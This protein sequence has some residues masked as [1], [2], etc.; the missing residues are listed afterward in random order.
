MSKEKKV[1]RLFTYLLLVLGALIFL[2]P[3]FYMLVAS[4]QSNTEIVG[5]GVN[6]R[7]GDQLIKNWQALM[8]RYNY[9]LVLWNSLVIAV[10]S[11]VL[12][13]VSATMAGY[14]LAKYK[15][16]GS[17]W[18]FNIVM[19]SRMV[20]FFATLIPLFYLM[21]RMGL[22][23]T[24]AGIVIPSIA[25]T[26]SV[27]MMRQYSH[28][29]PTSL[30]EAARMDGASEWIIFSKIAVPV[31]RP[32][33][34]TTG[35]LIFMGSWNQY[36][37][38][39]VMLSETDKFTIP[40]VIRNLSISSTGEVINYGALMLVLATSVIPMVLIYA[41]AQAKFKENDIGAANK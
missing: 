7:F 24:Y 31:L 12:A 3:Y 23:N 8:A 38:P 21:S 16:R 17:S 13:T 27:F 32:T 37:F 1:N 20:P 5:G 39:L 10:L 41:W 9:P 14:A 40:L 36:L 2:M 35:L 6:F 26:T 34:I 29:F 15:F 22:A 25:S 4:T 19:L 18:L 11:T 33:I 28:Q 30:M